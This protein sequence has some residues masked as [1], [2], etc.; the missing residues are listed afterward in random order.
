MRGKQSAI[1][2]GV[3][4]LRQAVSRRPY[5]RPGACIAWLT[6]LVRYFSQ[7]VKYGEKRLQE[8]VKSRLAGS[9]WPEAF[10]SRLSIRPELQRVYQ[11]DHAS[12]IAVRLMKGVVGIASNE[13]V[14][15][16]CGFVHFSP[17]LTQ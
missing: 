7:Q 8:R 16:M 5:R 15:D 13:A 12:P 14:F 4:G 6:A 3:E 10:S 1:I 11:R 9:T 2:G 17:L